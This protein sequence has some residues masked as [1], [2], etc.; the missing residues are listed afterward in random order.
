MP[1]AECLEL[2]PSLCPLQNNAW[3]PEASIIARQEPRTGNEQPE[4][5]AGTEGA[6]SSV[7]EVTW[8][9]L[10]SLSAQVR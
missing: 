2:P 7:S 9:H 5:G 4:S 8:Q 6:L 1:E 3:L 10:T